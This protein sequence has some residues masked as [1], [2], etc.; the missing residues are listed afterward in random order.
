MYLCYNCYSVCRRLQDRFDYH[1][2]GL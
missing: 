2:S 1:A